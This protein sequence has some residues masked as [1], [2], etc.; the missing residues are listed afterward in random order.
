MTDFALLNYADGEAAVPAIKV[1]D[2]V[3]AVR[4]ALAASGQAGEFP[5][6]STK[7]I[8]AHWDKAE[9]VLGRHRRQGGGRREGPGR[10]TAR[11]GAA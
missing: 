4:D 10:A 9:P 5:A 11:L 2:A 1:G 7:D 8:L 6:G 3:V